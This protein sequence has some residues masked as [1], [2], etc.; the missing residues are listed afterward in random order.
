MRIIQPITQSNVVDI[1]FKKKWVIRLSKVQVG[2]HEN[3]EKALKRLKKKLEREGV[4][5]ILKARKH[6]EKPSEKRRRKE[7]SSKTKKRF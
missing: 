3:L 5:K 7:R 4:L 1:N 2:E 6:Y